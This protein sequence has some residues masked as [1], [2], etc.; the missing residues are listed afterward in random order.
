MPCPNDD[1]SDGDLRSFHHPWSIPLTL[2]LASNDKIIYYSLLKL[3]A[4]EGHI[5]SV[6]YGKQ[7]GDSVFRRVTPIACI[8][9][10]AGICHSEPVKLILR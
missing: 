6:V 7:T 3:E 9:E 5:A 2:F 4:V 10:W 8:I 1:L